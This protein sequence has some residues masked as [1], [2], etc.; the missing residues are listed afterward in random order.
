M[1]VG[2]KGLLIYSVLLAVL[3]EGFHGKRVNDFTLAHDEAARLGL[4]QVNLAT[5]LSSTSAD[6]PCFLPRKN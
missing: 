5:N 3:V 2:D 4:G 1:P 6:F